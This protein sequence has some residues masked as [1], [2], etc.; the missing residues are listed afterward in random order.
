[1]QEYKNTG[2]SLLKRVLEKKNYSLLQWRS[3]YTVTWSS[4]RHTPLTLQPTP[5]LRP[6]QMDDLFIFSRKKGKIE[7]GMNDKGTEREGKGNARSFLQ[8]PPH[9]ESNDGVHIQP[10][11]RIQASSIFIMAMCKMLSYFHSGQL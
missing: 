9:P 10:T 4:N 7:R 6:T 8:R 3:Y 2:N 5:H 1:M 11:F